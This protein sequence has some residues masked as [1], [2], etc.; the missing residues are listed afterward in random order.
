MSE[1]PV[2]ELEAHVDDPRSASPD[3]G[4]RQDPITAALAL[5]DANLLQHPLIT[6]H[7]RLP[8]PAAKK[9]IE[10][11]IRYGRKQRNAVTWWAHPVT[12]KTSVIALLEAHLAQQ[13]E[14]CGI[15]FFEPD[16]EDEEREEKSPKRSAESRQL[17]FWSQLLEALEFTGKM[18]STP[19]RRRMQVS[20]ALLARSLPSR[21]LFFIIDEAQEMT[22]ERY[23]WLKKPVNWLTRSGVQVN[24]I[25]FAQFEII[26]KREEIITRYR[27]DIDERFIGEL[28]ELT[29]IRSEGDLAMPLEACDANSEFPAGSGYSYTALLAP[30]AFAAGLR[31]KS[32]APQLWKTFVS[33][34]P[35]KKGESGIAMEFVAEALSELA[36]LLAQRDSAT[37]TI[38]DE[39]LSKIVQ[40]SRWLSRKPVQSK[41]RQARK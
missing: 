36:L 14:G 24:F 20:R 41:S 9:A 12:G 18:E 10:L 34:S 19:S 26:K 15:L 40:N 38:T 27:S 23:I 7:A 5:R 6:K 30:R 13:F 28:Y 8:T 33:K 21:H 2:A 32:I 11:A 1:T 25:S 31:L 39:D 17:E 3:E 4:P 29:G 35:L 16:G 22:N 37:L